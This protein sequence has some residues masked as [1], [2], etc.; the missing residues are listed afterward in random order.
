MV[1]VPTWQGAGR[2]FR[3]M[4]VIAGPLEALGTCWLG[5]W[6]HWVWSCLTGCQLCGVGFSFFG[7]QPSHYKMDLRR[8]TPVALT[9]PTPLMLNLCLGILRG[10]LGRAAELRGAGLGVNISSTVLG[11]GVALLA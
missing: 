2:D 8:K 6:L 4:N 5:T 7:P 3:D 1:P 10:S 11:R 9:F